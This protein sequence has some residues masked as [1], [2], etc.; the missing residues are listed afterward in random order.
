MSLT[1]LLQMKKNTWLLGRSLQEQ[2][3]CTHRTHPP[4]VCRKYKKSVKQWIS[5]G[6]CQYVLFCTLNSIQEYSECVSSFPYLLTPGEISGHTELH[7]SASATSAHSPLVQ[8]LEPFQGTWNC[9]S[10]HHTVGNGKQTVFRLCIKS[11]ILTNRLQIIY[12][13]RLT[14]TTQ[15]IVICFIL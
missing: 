7:E 15:S 6:N 3:V 12:V 5:L 4:R 14:K 8:S 9:L 2:R 13:Q 11:Q 1:S 10:G